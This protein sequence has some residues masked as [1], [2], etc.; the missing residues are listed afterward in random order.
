MYWSGSLAKVMSNKF[1][2]AIGKD[3][4]NIKPLNR[5]VIIT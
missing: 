1:V 5:N 4:S 2:A 3:L